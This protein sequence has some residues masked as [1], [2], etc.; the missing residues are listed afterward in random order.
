MRIG[1]RSQNSNEKLDK[2]KFE[3]RL[4]NTPPSTPKTSKPRHHT[5]THLKKK[6]FV[7]KVTFTRA[8]KSTA[9][10]TKSKKCSGCFSVSTCVNTLVGGWRCLFRT[11]WAS[12]A[13]SGE[14]ASS[15]V[16]MA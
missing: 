14:S 5:H 11:T 10:R 13:S 2:H 4:K 7:L 6:L 12:A 9:S 15:T 3:N 8:G 1:T 16:W